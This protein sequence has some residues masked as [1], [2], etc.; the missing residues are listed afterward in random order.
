MTP[1]QLAQ[2]RLAAIADL[3]AQFIA[4]ADEAQRE[5]YGRLLERL[6]DIH[7]T[8]SLLPTLLAEY[9]A[10]VM[11]PL[12]YTYGQA[13][14]HLPQLNV[15]YFQGLDVAGYQALKAPLTSFLADRLGIDAQGNV[16]QGGYVD[17]LAGNTAASQKV[18]TF[19]YT[20]Q[21]SGTGITAY[22]EGLS[23][24][25][26]GGN[27]PAQGLV[28]DLYKNSLDD[29]NRNDRALQQLSSDRLGLKAAI[30]QGGLI[31]SSRLF[32]MKR[33]GKCFVAFE[34]AKMGT[35]ADAYGGYTNK[36]EGKFAGKSDPYDPFTDCGG[37]KCRHGWHYVPNTIALR[38]RPDLAE[39]DK[40]ALYIKAA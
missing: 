23:A 5:L 7:A 12:A 3:E 37:Y 33:N 11:V 35:K 16:L 9:H 21:A 28:L 40:G 14:L 1:E 25:V 6:Q 15:S 4:S 17:L 31:D 34:I 30:Y 10:A 18:L 36:A 13:M 26:L 39:D 22:R 38:M 24:L 32:C 29:F 19:A 8:P 20:A 2:Q 27:A